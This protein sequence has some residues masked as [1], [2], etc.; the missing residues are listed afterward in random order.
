ML[1]VVSI[2]PFD[3]ISV[4]HEACETKNVNVEDVCDAIAACEKSKF[5]V[6]GDMLNG[7]WELVSTTGTNKHKATGKRSGAGTY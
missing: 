1:E 7:E 2:A 3:A 5:N 6:T 4:M